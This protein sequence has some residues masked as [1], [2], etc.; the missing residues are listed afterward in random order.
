MRKHVF[1]EMALATLASERRRKDSYPRPTFETDNVRK[2]PVTGF[3]T[4]GV[5]DRVIGLRG[6]I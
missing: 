1:S 3:A 5:L 6:E 2:G 4:T